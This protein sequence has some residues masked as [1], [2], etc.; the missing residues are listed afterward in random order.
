MVLVKDMEVGKTYKVNG[1]VKTLVRKELAG[2]GGSGNQEPYFRLTFSD[3]S[4]I[5]K[6]WDDSFTLVE[7]ESMAT[8]LYQPGGRR[9]RRTRRGKRKGKKN[10]KKSP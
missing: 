7:N 6:D 8:T 5:T 3:G 2:S 10:Q 9:R 4:S 1:A